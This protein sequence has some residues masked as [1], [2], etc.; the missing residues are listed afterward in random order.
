MVQHLDLIRIGRDLRGVLLE[1]RRELQDPD[2]LQ[3]VRIIDVYEI[4]VR[5]SSTISCDLS[6]LFSY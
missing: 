2:G 3:P 1:E 4:D 6:N 5:L